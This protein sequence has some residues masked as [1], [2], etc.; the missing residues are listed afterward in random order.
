MDKK[1][2][3]SLTLLMLF[4][5]PAILSVIADGDRAT[6]IYVDDDNSEG[7]WDGSRE[8]PYRFIQHGIDAADNGDTV[9]VFAGNYY[10]HLEIRVSLQ[11]L[12]EHKRMIALWCGLLFVSHPVQTQAVTYI[13]QRMASLATLFYLSS[14]CF[15]LKARLAKKKYVSLLGFS[16]SAITAL[17]GMFTKCENCNGKRERSVT[18]TLCDECHGLMLKGESYHRIMVILANKKTDY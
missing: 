8:H 1:L 17:L 11:L 5:I 18:H 16:G 9:Y 7:P 15:Y 13:V 6:I 3:V 14:L 2:F 10:E 4:F 12:G